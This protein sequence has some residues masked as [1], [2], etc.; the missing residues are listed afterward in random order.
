MYMGNMAK[1]LTAIILCAAMGLSFSACAG[2]TEP[3]STSP[4][5]GIANP[6]QASTVEDMMQ[7]TGV[8][9]DLS[10][11]GFDA[12]VFRYNFEPVMYQIVLASAD[13]QQ[14]TLR[15]QQAEE[16]AD[17]SGMYFS[18]TDTQPSQYGNGQIS[19]TAE[20]QGI[21]LWWDKGYTFS[22]SADSNATYDSMDSIC[23]AVVAS[24]K[25]AE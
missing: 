16:V 25:V 7:E 10:E 3:E 22:L 11:L 24:V 18:W 5:M 12:T 2:K 8:S 19:T 6:M 13:G 14:Y 21:C 4:Q 17:I 15:F 20:G 23:S 1:K 9:V